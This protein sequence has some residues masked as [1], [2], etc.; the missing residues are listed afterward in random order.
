M[1][2]YFEVEY[3]PEAVNFIKLRN[4]KVRRKILYNI[5]LAKHTKSASLF[6]RLSGEIWEFRTIYEKNY[7]RLFAFWDKTKAAYVICSHGIIKK[8]K[9]T[10][11]REIHRAEE[12]R[13]K[14]FEKS[15]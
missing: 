11:L 6:T 4:E 2:R 15:I 9:K 8:S 3:L 1:K 14:Y 13:K 5:S 7:Y 12:I 10:P